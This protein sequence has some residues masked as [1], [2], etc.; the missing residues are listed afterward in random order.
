MLCLGF[1]RKNAFNEESRWFAQQCM[2]L[3]PWFMESTIL[4]VSL[5]VL[6]L[7]KF[8]LILTFLFC[9]RFINKSFMSANTDS[10]P[11]SYKIE[12]PTEFFF[13]P[14]LY[15][16]HVSKFYICFKVFH[17]NKNTISLLSKSV[18]FH[19]NS[20]HFSFDHYFWLITC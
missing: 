14:V 7:H 8:L 13:W 16:Q 18:C 6:L 9:F 20:S 4:P 5:F 2:H 11:I 15:T 19:Q 10:C 17:L 12:F 3:I 1:L